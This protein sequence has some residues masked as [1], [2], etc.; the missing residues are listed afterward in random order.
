M[1]TVYICVLVPSHGQVDVEWRFN[2][3]KN[4]LVVNL[5]QLWRKEQR[6]G[7]DALIEMDPKLQ[8]PNH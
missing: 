3:K 7:Y 2:I 5:Q 1:F 4:S 8:I 6:C